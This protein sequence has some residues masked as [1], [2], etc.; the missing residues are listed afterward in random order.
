M[1]YQ[2]ECGEVFDVF[3]CEDEEC[4]EYYF[5]E[6]GLLCESFIVYCPNCRKKLRVGSI[7]RYVSTTV[8]PA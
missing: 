4:N 8:T 1:D 7:Y 6:D 3:Y 5:N 2:C